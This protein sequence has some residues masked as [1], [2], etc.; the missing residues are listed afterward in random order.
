MLREMDDDAPL[1]IPDWEILDHALH[2]YFFHHFLRRALLVNDT[3]P[4]PRYDRL[5]GRSQRAHE[6]D[7]KHA[8]RAGR[9][10]SHD[11]R[12]DAHLAQWV[13]LDSRKLVSIPREEVY[14]RD[15]V[16]RREQGGLFRGV[17]GPRVDLGIV[18]PERGEGNRC[19]DK[20]ERRSLIDLERQM[21]NMGH[22]VD[23]EEGLRHTFPSHEYRALS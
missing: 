18:R 20:F 15:C 13:E 3:E 17:S 9:E 8:Q 10:L 23:N 21:L 6:G 7:I 12:A 19:D 5:A 4:C 22:D 2:R 1:V 14:I 11:M 16:Q